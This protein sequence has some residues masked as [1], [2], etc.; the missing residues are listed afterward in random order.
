[1]A[2]SIPTIH[3]RWGYWL[4]IGEW[5]I[6]LLFSIEYLLRMWVSPKPIK[7]I[8]SFYGVIDLLSI[9]PTFISLLIPGAQS[10][11][12]VRMLRLTRVFRILNMER[13][14]REARLLLLAL[15]AS[16]H[17]LIVFMLAFDTSAP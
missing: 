12:L 17:R 8:T 14:V 7:Y 1:M 10:L 13:Y 3:A 16:R 2:D 15:I 11:V 9:I 4:L 6:T 5:I